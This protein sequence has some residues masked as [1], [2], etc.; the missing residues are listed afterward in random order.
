MNTF[1]RC[2]V[3]ALLILTLAACAAPASQPA[4]LS[5]RIDEPPSHTEVAAGQSVLIESTATDAAGIVRVELLVDGKVVK[6][7]EAPG[8]QKSFNVVQPWTAE[9]AGEHTV[10]VRAINTAN[11][12][13]APAAITLIVT[14]AA[15]PT[16]APAPTAAPAIT[17]T[18]A[19]TVSPTAV[20]TAVVT[21][22]ATLTPTKPAPTA[23]ATVVTPTVAP[24]PTP[25]VPIIT[26]F[27][28]DRAKINRGESVMLHWGKVNN[29]ERVELVGIGVVT[30]PGAHSVAPAQTTTYTL[31]AICHGTVKTAQVTI[32]VTQPP[33]TVA[34]RHQISGQWAAGKYSMQLAEAI[35]CR[36]PV[37]NVTGSYAVWTGGTPETAKVS[38]TVNVNTG[39]VSLKISAEMPGAPV[40]TFNGTLSSDSK[41]LNGAL[42]GVGRLTFVKE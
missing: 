1:V 12:M 5:I 24:T 3:L 39:A 21:A 25:C 28:A 13:S 8:P 15:A 6:T 18:R 16:R 7:S 2:T 37:C 20:A 35:G 34:V 36:G 23:I 30:T 32:T 14:T 11:V 41:R 33:P 42:S 40:R 10:S 17:A 38:G 29:V 4:V 31:R 27:T 22:T 19:I 26:S 9:G